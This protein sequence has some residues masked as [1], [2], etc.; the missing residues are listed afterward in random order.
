MPPRKL[1][2]G[3]L[4]AAGSLAGS[5]LFRRRAARRR[6][7]VDLY[8]DD[9]SMQ[10][11]SDG[12]AR[13]GAPAP[14][15]ARAPRA[16][17]HE[18]RTSSR[19]AM[20]EAAYLEGDFVLR[21]GRALQYYLDKY[22]FETRPDLLGALGAAIAAAVREHEPEADRLAGARA[23]RGRARRGGLARDRPAVRD[24]PQGG[25]GLRHR[26]PARGRSFEPGERVCLVEDVV[27]SG[28]AAIEAVEALREAG[29]VCPT[30]S[31]WSTAKKAASTRSPRHARAALA[32]LPGLRVA[33]N[34]RKSAWLSDI[35][36]RC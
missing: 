32:A 15:R 1:V 16:R 18:P 14:D 36:L 2:T 20:R 3:M 29:L 21:S 5:V 4:L 24:R 6:E 13:G 25:E 28:G 19:A 9:G 31:A 10:S 23:R 11:Y 27:T 30:R 7:R 22:R 8:A 12:D 26:Q 35:R 34:P 17:R 33:R